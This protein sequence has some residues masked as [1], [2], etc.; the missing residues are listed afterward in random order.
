MIND[1]TVMVGKTV[2]LFPD[3]F[4][5]GGGKAILSDRRCLVCQNNLIYLGDISEIS[6]YVVS[7]HP[8]PALYC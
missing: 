5:N 4:S 3:F 1:F 6:P 2:F 8:R 7:H